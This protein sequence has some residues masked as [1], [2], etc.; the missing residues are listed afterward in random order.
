MQDLARISFYKDLVGYLSTYLV[1]EWEGEKQKQEKRCIKN[2]LAGIGKILKE[3]ANLG[4]ALLSLRE[5]RFRS[6]S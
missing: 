1:A 3:K 5:K 2:R 6:F 4:S